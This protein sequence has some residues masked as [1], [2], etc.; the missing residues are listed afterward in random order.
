MKL[1]Q[2]P[3]VRPGDSVGIVS[4]SFVAPAIFPME[5]DLGLA[6]LREQF[7]L[8]PV[9]LPNVRNPQATNEDKARDLIEAFTN[10]AIKAVITTIGGDHQIEYVH[11]LPAE[12]FRENPKPFFGYSDNTHLCNFLFRNGI[13]SFYGGC[14]YTEYARQG[15]MDEMTSRYLRK[16]LFDGGKVSLEAS[17]EFND[18]DLFWG[19]E[20][21]LTRRRRYQPDV[22]WHWDG[23]A[24]ARGITWGGCLESVDEFLRHGAPIPSLSEFEGLVLFLETSEEM[25]SAPIVRRVLR[26]LGER[27]ILSRAQGLLVGRPKAWC[28]EQPRSDEEKESY[29]R[30]QR[31]VV[32]ATARRYNASMPIVQNLDFGHT[33]PS[34]CLPYG[35]EI[36]IDS[37]ARSIEVQF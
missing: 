35:G 12:P 5:Y 16:A 23:S 1:S 11:K 6:R 31:E 26:A 25:P 27:G 7:G 21:N 10:P 30:E 14:I 28:F 13:P 34:I 3:K 36:E 17:L 29:K 9:E 24:S 37:G 32:I 22:G 19:K 15:A 4:P 33:A 2:L 20:E 18:E 8:N